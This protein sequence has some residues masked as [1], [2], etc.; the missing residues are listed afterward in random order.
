MRVH[1]TAVARRK[2]VVTA[3]LAMLEMLA[4]FIGPSSAAP[5]AADAILDRI[6]V[7]NDQDDKIKTLYVAGHLIKSGD[8]PLRTKFI[9][10]FN[11][12]NY[13][14]FI[15]SYEDC[16]PLIYSTNNT[17]ITYDPLEN[18]VFYSNDDTR[19]YF[20]LYNKMGR[21]QL[22]MA[23]F[24]PVEGRTKPKNRFYIDL[25]SLMANSTKVEDK[26]IDN[27]RHVALKGNGNSIHRIVLDSET[28]YPIKRYDLSDDNG[29]TFL[30]IDKIEIDEPVEGI[31]F[32]LPP[33]SSFKGV[34]PIASPHI[35]DADV[36]QGNKMVP[37][38]DSMF[39]TILAIHED[40]FREKIQ[41]SINYKVS[42]DAVVSRYK[43]SSKKLKSIIE[44]NCTLR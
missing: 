27:K 28:S 36:K 9:F 26:V 2:V 6:P 33:R 31:R 5:P 23:A 16:V 32:D 34:I 29:N 13:S 17:T 25:Q 41:N 40:K 3:L 8:V 7:L 21:N 12:N 43:V 14:L 4:C 19:I 37:F 10:Y 30:H 42:W 44:A 22:Q 38:V 1:K 39:L 24:E 18:R 35:G 15:A 20:S 11:N